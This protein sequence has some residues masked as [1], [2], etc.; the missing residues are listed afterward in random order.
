MWFLS[1]WSI[2]RVDQILYLKVTYEEFA[3]ESMVISLEHIEEINY[4][5]QSFVILSTK[6]RRLKN[7][8]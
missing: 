5:V 3:E 2:K 1:I 4:W 6:Q 7:T 8:H